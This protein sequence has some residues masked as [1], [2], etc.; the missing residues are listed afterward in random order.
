LN[1]STSARVWL[2]VDLDAL[3]LNY[4]KIVATVHPCEAIAVL[5]ANAYGMGV[6]AVSKALAHAGCSCFGVADVQEAVA[7]S[8]HPNVKVQILGA[9]LPDE[10]YPAAEAGV[11][12]PCGDVDTAMRIRDAGCRI[13]RPVRAHFL[14]DSGMGRLGCPIAEALPFIEAVIGWDE[15]NWEGI[16]S[17]FPVAYRTGGEYTRNQIMSMRALLDV[18]AGK[19]IVFAWRHIANSDAV[20]NFPAS[21]EAP[22]NAVRTGINLY[23]SFDPEGARIMNLRPVVSLKTRIA[24]IRELSEGA[25]VGYGCTYRL[26]KRMRVGTIPVGY[27]DGMPMSLSNR[28]HVLVHGTPCHIIG[29]V[30]M[31]YTTI[32]LDT[33]PHAVCGDEVTCL[34]GDGPAAITPDHWAVLKGSHAY[35]ILCSIGPRVARRYIGGKSNPVLE[36][37]V[38]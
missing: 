12:L 26:P 11:V 37:A 1:T 32:A 35:D 2:D 33:V 36:P 38:Q 15:V 27:A 19:G 14:I 22:F 10:I 20:N 34:G 4:R 30:S 5:K 6:D 7:L 13:G 9:I 23:G 17:H 28:A 18:L 24:T 8:K 25:C 29:R 31:D 21:Y 3:Q 16:Y